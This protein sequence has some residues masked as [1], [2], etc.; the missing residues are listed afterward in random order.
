V[1]YPLIARYPYIRR[2]LAWTGT[3]ICWASLLGASYVH[4]VSRRYFLLV[5]LL[6]TPVQVKALLVLQGICYGI[7][8]SLLYAPCISLLNEWFVAR[9]GL[10]NG[11]LTAGTSIGGLVLPIVLPIPIERFGIAVTIRG[12]SVAILVVLGPIMPFIRGRLP[13]TRARTT[14]SHA[15][16]RNRVWLKN[17]TFWILVAM[18]TMQSFAYYIPAMWLPSES[19][20]SMSSSSW[21]TDACPSVRCLDRGICP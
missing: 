2:P 18:N 21:L 12:L 9:R 6:L 4:D 8:G 11:V 5:I 1:L 7:G 3:V 14:A 17:P 10:A 13:E 20:C 16:P 15:H 19:T